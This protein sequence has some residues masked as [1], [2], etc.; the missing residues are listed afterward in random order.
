VSAA[1][2]YQRQG[3]FD[4]ANEYYLAK[5]FDITRVFY[6]PQYR[7]FAPARV[8]GTVKIDFVVWNPFVLPVEVYGTYWHRG[9]LGAD[10]RFREARIFKHFRREVYAVWEYESDSLEHALIVARRIVSGDTI[11]K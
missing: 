4:S 8:V 6:Q 7:L 10:D 11:S 3:I 9:E 1:D 5:A 2:V